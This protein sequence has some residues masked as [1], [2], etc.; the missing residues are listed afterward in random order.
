MPVHPAE[1][2]LRAL[3]VLYEQKSGSVVLEDIVKRTRLDQALVLEVL[4]A[5]THE[6]LVRRQQL[7][8]NMGY[9]PFDADAVPLSAALTSLFAV[10]DRRPIPDPLKEGGS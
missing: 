8:R 9:A 6:R 4:L 3:H 5:L 2:V 1:V 10:L 7:G